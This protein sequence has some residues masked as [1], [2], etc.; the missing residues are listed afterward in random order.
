MGGMHWFILIVVLLAGLAFYNW[1]NSQ[2]QLSLLKKQGFTLSEDLK[3]QPNLLVDIQARELAVV[4]PKGFQRYH[5]DRVQRVELRFDTGVQQPENYH[6]YILLDGASPLE[7][8]YENEW[9]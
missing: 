9:L 1:Q 3:G 2:N 8:H 7:I 4:T 6:L 5:F